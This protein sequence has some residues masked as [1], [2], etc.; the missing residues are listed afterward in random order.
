MGTRP[1]LSLTLNRYDFRGRLYS[2]MQEIWW[3]VRDRRQS[4]CSGPTSAILAGVRPRRKYQIPP[5]ISY[6]TP[7]ASLLCVPCYFLIPTLYQL[8]FLFATPPTPPPKPAS[9]N[10]PTLCLI[11]FPGIGLQHEAIAPNLLLVVWGITEMGETEALEKAWLV[12]RV[13]IIWETP[14]CG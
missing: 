9:Y 2:L 6:F 10:T 7:T 4:R 3:K 13:R 12:G 5:I 14:Y 11:R 1:S 8:P